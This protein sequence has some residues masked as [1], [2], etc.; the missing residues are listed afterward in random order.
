MKHN[1]N[2]NITASPRGG[3][4]SNVSRIP[5]TITKVNTIRRPIPD[6][7]ASGWR[8]PNKGKNLGRGISLDMV[9]YAECMGVV[10]DSRW[11]MGC[12]RE[13]G[14]TLWRDHGRPC[15]REVRASI[16]A[17]KQGNACGAKGGRK[18]YR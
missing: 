3:V 15:Q 8:S 18:T 14:R 9:A 2:E 4:G 7:P 10:G 16:V 5:S 13:G 17:E 1:E 12:T 11:K 6:E